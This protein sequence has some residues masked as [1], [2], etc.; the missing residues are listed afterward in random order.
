MCVDSDDNLNTGCEQ[1]RFVPG[2]DETALPC[3][4]GLYKQF[5]VDEDGYPYGC[6]GLEYFNRKVLGGPAMSDMKYSATWSKTNRNGPNPAGCPLTNLAGVYEEYADDSNKFVGD[7]VPA[8]EKM[9][10][11]GV[12]FGS[13]AAAKP[14]GSKSAVCK[15]PDVSS[16]TDFGFATMQIV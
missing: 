9:L 2:I 8:L 3:E 11:N 12:D 1:W 7:F 6:P 16:R 15:R 10:S 13:S 14:I 4:M 5:S